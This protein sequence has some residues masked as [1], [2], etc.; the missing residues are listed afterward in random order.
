[1]KLDRITGNTENFGHH[2][3][4]FCTNPACES[5]ALGRQ[6]AEQPQGCHQLPDDVY[7][8]EC[9]LCRHRFEVQ[10]QSSARAEVAPVI[11]PG[12]S[13]I[14]VPCPWCGHRNEY[15]AELWPLVN[16]D[17]LFAISPITAFGVYCNECHA[18]YTLRPKAE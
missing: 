6:V 3:Q 11:S 14:T 12:L 7:L 13:S 16:S 18:A 9:C 15:K 8:Y 4:G 1:M 17:G 2:L 10:E 5:G